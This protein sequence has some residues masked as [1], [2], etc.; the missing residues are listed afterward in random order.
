MPSLWVVV[1]IKMATKETINHYSDEV[2]LLPPRPAPF[3]APFF[4]FSVLSQ[5]ARSSVIFPQLHSR[6]QRADRRCVPEPGVRE[7]NNASRPQL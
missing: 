6:G 7:W 4:V 5:S 2:L 1:V 3:S